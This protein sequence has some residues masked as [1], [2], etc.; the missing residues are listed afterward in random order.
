MKWEQKGED[1]VDIL[2]H[3]NRYVPRLDACTQK[4]LLFGGDMLT[5]E[6]SAHSC[7][8]KLQSATPESRLQGIVPKCEDWHALVTFHQV[9]SLQ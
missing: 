7:D 8:S 9:Y 1:M 6:Q 4:P 3:I 5:R 2:R